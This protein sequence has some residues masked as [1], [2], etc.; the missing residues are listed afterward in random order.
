[1]TRERRRCPLCCRLE[2]QKH[3]LFCR[4]RKID[5]RYVGGQK[6]VDNAVTRAGDGLRPFVEAMEKAEFDQKVRKLYREFYGRDML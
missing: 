5:G 4:G 2:G 1:M 6:A 3:T